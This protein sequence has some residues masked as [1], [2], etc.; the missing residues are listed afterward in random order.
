MKLVTFV[1]PSGEPRAGALV[2]EAKTVVDLA[3]AYREIFGENATDLEQVLVMIEGGDN[4]LDRAYETLKKIPSDS[5]YRRADVRLLAPVPRPPQMRDCLCFELHLVQAFNAARQLKANNAPDPAAALV[6][7][8]R[9]GVLRVPS[10]F[11]DQPI[12]YKCNRFAVIGTDE[13]V[14]WPSYSRML[15]FELEFGCFIKKAAKDVP[16]ASARDYIFGYTIFNDFTARD[17]QT[18]EMGGQLGPAKGKDFDT[19][20]AMGPC[21]VT[22]DEMKDP[23]NLTM[24]ARVNGEEWGRGKSDSM[25]WSFEDLI[26]WISRS[27]TIH[28]G[29]FLGS[30]TVGNGCGL[31]Q[32]RFLKAD[33]TVELEVE[34]IGILRNTV[35]KRF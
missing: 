13:D 19:A 10:T 11:Y 28:P 8:E 34:G 31:E 16:A 21:L 12:Y 22:A 30:G 20:N 2:D 14:L 9:T 24:I 26:A 25:Y 17:A 29:E 18:E 3:A 32:M 7:M 33:D 23:Y 5:V 1:P 15:D 4:S 6:E 27:E 35:R